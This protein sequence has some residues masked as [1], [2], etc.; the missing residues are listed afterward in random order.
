MSTLHF[1]DQMKSR[2]SVQECD[3]LIDVLSGVR[4]GKIERSAE[5]FG[6]NVKTVVNKL[7]AQADLLEGIPNEANND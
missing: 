3:F 4:D 1:L 2:L 7:S 5:E 6:A